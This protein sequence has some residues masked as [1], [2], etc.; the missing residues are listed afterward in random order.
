MLDRIKTYV[1]EGFSYYGL[2]VC[3]HANGLRFHLVQVQQKK[4]ELVILEEASFDTLQELANTVQ[5]ELPFFLTVHTKEVLTKLVA[6]THTDALEAV[7]HASFPNLDFTSFYYEVVKAK[8]Q[9]LISICRKEPLDAFLE[10]LM[11][12]QLK[13]VAISLGFSPISNSTPY[14]P[15]GKVLVS[16][17]ELTLEGEKVSA[18][19]ANSGNEH[20][21]YTVN[22]LAV[23]NTHLLGFSS[24][25]GYLLKK[26]NAQGNLQDA[27]AHLRSDFIHKRHFKLLLRSSLVCILGLLFINFLIFNHYYEKVGA[28]EETLAVND[29]NKEQL[30]RLKAEVKGK[31]DRLNAVLAMANSRTSLFLDELVQRLPASLLLNDVLYQPLQKPIRASKPVLLIHNN[32]IVSGQASNNSDFYSWIA[33]LEQLEWVDHVETTNYDYSSRNSS[34]FSVK[35]SI[36]ER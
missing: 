1:N 15:S 2:E 14:L 20:T 12:L 17:K 10:E 28:I 3:E 6:S 9:L 18:I 30:L 19:T 25:L 4:Q 21:T 31:E 35:I 5:K 23:K 8:E 11:A 22:G 34:N 7:V 13:V 36:N 32:M 29:A 16:T 26:T 24:I 33:A 27:K